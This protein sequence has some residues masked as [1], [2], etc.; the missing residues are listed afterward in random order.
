MVHAFLESLGRMACLAS[1][2]NLP[3]GRYCH[4]KIEEQVGPKETDYA[5]RITHELLWRDWIGGSLEQQ[6]VDILLYV[7]DLAS[8]AENL[9]TMARR[10][11]L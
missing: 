6:H 3:T 2:R 11:T 5:M 4:R 1:C 10:A 9:I 7:Q 8:S